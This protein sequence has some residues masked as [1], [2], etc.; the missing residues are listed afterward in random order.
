MKA[1]VQ[2]TIGGLFACAAA[3]ILLYVSLTTGIGP[4]IAPTLVLGA[5][6]LMNLFR[7]GSSC[8][9][10]SASSDSR[11]RDFIVT[12]QAVGS[13]GGSIAT[14]LGFSL[15]TLAFLEPDLFA[16]HLATPLGF[17]FWVAGITFAAGLLGRS[18]A[19]NVGPALLADHTVRFPVS[20]AIFQTI[21]SHTDAIQR[22]LL[23]LGLGI[24]TLFTTLTEGVGTLKPLIARSYAL[25]PSLLGHAV[26]FEIA[27]FFWSIG[28]LAGLKIA[29][30]LAAGMLSKYIVIA[31]LQGY[32]SAMTEADLVM[33]F[34]T[35]VVVTQACGELVPNIY[36]MAKNLWG[37]YCHAAP[38]TWG[39]STPQQ[40]EG[41][42]ARVGL[43]VVTFLKRCISFEHALPLSAVLVTLF[44]YDFSLLEGL[45]LIAATWFA[46][47]S[48]V[49]FAVKTGLAPYGRFMTFVMI[50]MMVLFAP[51][52][53]NITLLCLFVAVAG[54][55]ACDLVMQWR[56]GQSAG[57]S[58]PKISRAQLVGLVVSAVAVGFFFWLLSA[59]LGLGTGALVAH[60]GRSRALLLMSLSCHLVPAIAGGIYSLI[61]SRL[62][63]N[64]MLA[65]GGLIMPNGITIGLFIGAIVGKYVGEGKRFYPICSGIFAG[66]ALWVFGQLIALLL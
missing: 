3:A 7:I 26:E 18:I 8:A 25:F 34:C 37:T 36:K 54:A 41:G 59:K 61:L 55:V 60:R 58:L 23:L 24:S 35:G 57:I 9:N 43:S 16:Q 63:I 13:V 11:E 21:K 45:V 29:L 48:L 14:A 1:L 53:T 17:T 51:S 32:F 33:S 56:V 64:P 30:P 22:R 28:Y 40:E 31:P 46:V 66:K 6:V 19:S 52:Y 47:S 44:W 20:E 10:T 4:W 2:Y 15:P 62:S 5:S 49:S 50:P 65:F 27:P 42:I 12:T 38:E 39:L